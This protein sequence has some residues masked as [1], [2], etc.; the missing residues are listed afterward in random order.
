M[1][2]NGDDIF[3]MTTA[4]L[5]QLGSVFFAFRSQGF[6]DTWIGWE[7]S[8]RSPRPLPSANTPTH[9]ALPQIGGRR[10]GGGGEAGGVR[11]RSWCAEPCG[12]HRIVRGAA[13]YSEG[14]GWGC[15]LELDHK[16]GEGKV[17]A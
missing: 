13:P 17:D 14:G 8:A 6:G 11:A 10:G 9:Q 7:P 2:P 16:G 12:A 15:G 4:V 3:I 1:I 5:F